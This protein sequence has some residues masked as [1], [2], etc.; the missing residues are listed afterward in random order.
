MTELLPIIEE[1]AD[2]RAQIQ[3]AEWLLS[4]PIA[5]LRRYRSTIRNRLMHS[6]CHA[7]L[8]Y[9]DALDAV[10]S[11]TRSCQSGLL[12][13]EAADAM[14]AAGLRLRAWAASADAAARKPAPG[15]SDTDL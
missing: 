15:P 13:P 11:S 2:A 1:L 9:L 12:A 7:G 5:I 3:R 4:C 10:M 14:F 6:G 8:D